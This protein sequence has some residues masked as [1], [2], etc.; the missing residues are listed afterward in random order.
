[1]LAAA[2][3]AR[4][5]SRRVRISW[6]SLVTRIVCS[7]CADRLRSLVTTVQPSGSSFTCRLPALT[8][9]SMVKHMPGSSTRSAVAGIAVVQHLRFFVEFATDAVAAVLAHHREFVCLDEGLDGVADVAERGPGRTCGDPACMAC[10]VTFTS[11]RA[12]TEG[13]PTKNILLVSPWKPSLMTVMSMLT[14]SPF[15]RRLLP[16]MPWQTWL[17][18]EVQIERGKPL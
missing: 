6:P 16:G 18:T 14:I 17:L 8:M 7:H 4:S 11:R 3:R 15:F 5:S 2:S 10:W 13:S 9:G 12:S 1:M